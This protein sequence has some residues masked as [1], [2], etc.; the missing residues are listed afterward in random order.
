MRRKSGPQMKTLLQE[1]ENNIECANLLSICPFEA[2]TSAS[3][4][5]GKIKR[6]DYTLPWNLWNLNLRWREFMS[7]DESILPYC[8]KGGMRGAIMAIEPQEDPRGEMAIAEIAPSALTICGGGAC[9]LRCRLSRYQ[10]LRCL[11]SRYRFSR[12]LLLRY[13]LHKLWYPCAGDMTY[14]SCIFLTH[15]DVKLGTLS[16]L[17]RRD[18][19]AP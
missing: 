6:L 2:S 15:L 5:T 1:I 13:R 14:K 7:I 9:S 8:K 10:F 4:H 3:A 18:T 16:K 17:F 19:I 12:C 11:L